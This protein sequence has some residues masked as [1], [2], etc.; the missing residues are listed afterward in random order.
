MNTK[1][2]HD[3]VLLLIYPII[4]SVVT[5]LLKANVFVSI[6]IFLVIPAIFLS[7]RKS[8]QVKKAAIFSLLLG[9]PF[10]IIIY[11]IGHVTKAW[12]MDYTIFPLVFDFVNIEAVLWLIIWIYFTVLFYEYFFDKHVRPKLW[13][14][15]MKYLVL[16]VFSLFSVFLLFFLR[17]SSI[18]ERI[19]Y[20]Y[21]LMGFA[22][23]V[24]PILL[25]LYNSPAQYQAFFKTQA[26]F[27]Y[28]N[29]IYELNGLALGWWSFP[30]DEFIG[31]VS[32]FGLQFP[33]EEFIFWIAIGAMAILSYYKAFDD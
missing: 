11:Y 15:N 18:L 12:I 6:L 30:G 25:Y 33:L 28:F 21:L 8:D 26:Y 5:L 2:R 24:V 9:T 10:I 31:W 3:L 23:V 22:A 7:I 16:L 32:F 17:F 13:Y 29:L 20:S 4:A 27:L 14:P 19:P 1:K